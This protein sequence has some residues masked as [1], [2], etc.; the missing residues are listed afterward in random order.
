MKETSAKVNQEN[1]VRKYY[2]SEFS[3]DD[4]E[5][6]ITFNIID[7]DFYR[8]NITVAISRCGKITQDTFPLLRDKDGKLYFEFG[9]FYENKISL[10]DFQEV[11]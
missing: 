1:E 4:G 9:I 11:K 2:L 10:D 8:Q 7:I 3:Y 5:Y 6:E